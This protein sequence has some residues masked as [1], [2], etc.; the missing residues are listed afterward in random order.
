MV[1]PVV[2]KKGQWIWIN[3][4]SIRSQKWNLEILKTDGNLFLQ[5]VYIQW[6][7][8]VV[9][10]WSA[11]GTADPNIGLVDQV[12]GRCGVDLY[13]MMYSCRLIPA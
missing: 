8:S 3:I 13:L 4:P 11:S 1:V 9:V 5:K 12:L 7:C 6:P 10:F 2:W